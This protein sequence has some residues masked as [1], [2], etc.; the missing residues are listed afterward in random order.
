MAD[1]VKFQTSRLSTPPTG[2]E[3][4]ADV[5]DGVAYQ[6]VK[7]VVGEDGV[8]EDFSQDSEFTITAASLSRLEA[9]NEQI[10]FQ[11]EIMNKY[12]SILTNEEI[13]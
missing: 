12:L 4:A 1:N 5:V 11:L 13:S 8:V 2:T 7:I 3:V 6:R 10:L 9:L